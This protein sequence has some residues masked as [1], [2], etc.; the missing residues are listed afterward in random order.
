MKDFVIFLATIAAAG[1][2]GF[3]GSSE[4]D[5]EAA[6]SMSVADSLERASYYR[7]AA[8]EYGIV[9]ESHPEASFYPLAVR[10]AAL[11]NA[12]PLN[13]AANDSIALYWLG[14]YQN[15]NVS[16]QERENARVLA[17]Q[18]RRVADLRLELSRQR[19]FTDSLSSVLRRESSFLVSQSHRIEELENN[20]RQTTNEL[21]RLKEIDLRLQRNR[22]RK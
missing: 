21:K 20:L 10:K 1:C 6:R 9:A 13:P 3:G 7:E 11:L 18:L 2:S 15:L 5:A 19:R 17:A 14:V 22:G 12:T 4:N 8:L 16:R